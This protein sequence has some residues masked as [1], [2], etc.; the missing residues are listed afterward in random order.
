MG[1]GYSKTHAKSSWNHGEGR[2]TAASRGYGHRWRV[3]RGLKLAKD[4]LCELCS[5][6]G[7]VVVATCVDHVKT[8]A[9]RR[10]EAKGFVDAADVGLHELRSLCQPCHERATLE[11]QGKRTREPVPLSGW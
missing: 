5:T 4:P 10:R 3:V 6:K 8:M 2:E 1:D 9:E 7:L 11:Q